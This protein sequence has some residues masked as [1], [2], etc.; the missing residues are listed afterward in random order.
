[1]GCHIP[2]MK[3]EGHAVSLIFLCKSIKNISHNPLIVE[4]KD[5]RGMSN[6]VIP[7]E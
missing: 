6:H 3:A 5:P 2:N 1:M 7:V 4:I